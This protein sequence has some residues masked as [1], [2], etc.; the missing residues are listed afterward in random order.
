MT[1]HPTEPIDWTS[2]IEID[3]DEWVEG[4]R[5]DLDK[6]RKNPEDNGL[7]VELLEIFC[8]VPLDHES[9]EGRKD[10]GTVFEIMGASPKLWLVH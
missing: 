6:M 10:L 8:L 3:P 4:L 9:A 1:V 7:A 2:I 5:A